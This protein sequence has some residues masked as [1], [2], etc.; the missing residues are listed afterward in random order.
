MG[1]IECA[2]IK[3]VAE[4]RASQL[5]KEMAQKGERRRRNNG[6]LDSDIVSLSDL[7]ITRKQSSR[8]QLMA[9]VPRVRA[10][11][12]LGTCSITPKR[13]GATNIRR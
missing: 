6:K 2:A 13:D 3:I 1:A 7:G 4:R 5:L 8:W 12:G 10:C 11:S 9:N